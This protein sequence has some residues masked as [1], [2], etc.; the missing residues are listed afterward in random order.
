ME[1]HEIARLLDLVSA[2]Y[3][4]SKISPTKVLDL[5]QNKKELRDFPNQRRADL[6]NLVLERCKEFPSLPELLSAC[7][8]VNPR[9]RVIKDT[10]LVCDDTRWI[11]YGLFHETP[12]GEVKY[13]ATDDLLPPVHKYKVIPGATTPDGKP[14]SKQIVFSYGGKP[15][16]YHYP[17]PCPICVH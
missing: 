9:P 11:H 14:M 2:A 4:N 13:E 16:E 10:C 12:S 3:P 8:A 17:R 6:F 7:E 1:T 15:I 5:W